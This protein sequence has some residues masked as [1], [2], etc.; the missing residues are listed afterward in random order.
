MDSLKRGWVFQTNEKVTI[1][2]TDY[3]RVTFFKNTPDFTVD[4]YESKKFDKRS[5]LKGDY[6]CPGTLVSDCFGILGIV[7]FT[8]GPYLVVVTDAKKC[9]T[10]IKE[11]DVYSI[12]GKIL[13]PLFYPCSENDMETYYCN[14]FN[15]FDIS[16]NFYFSYTYNIA[17]SLQRNV[18]YA[19]CTREDET[20]LR[21]DAVCATQKYRYNFVH[22][23][24]FAE[25]FGRDSV[26][27]CLTVIHGFF[28]QTNVC[29]SGRILAVHLIARR[30]RFYAG[31]RYK[32]RGISSD[33]H[34][35]ND[36]ETEQILDDA[37]CTASV[38]SFLQVRGS[39]PAFWAQDKSKTIM[40]KPPLI[41]TQNDPTFT[42]QKMHISELLSLY[43][44]PIIMLNLLSDDPGTEEGKLSTQFQSAISSINVEL[45]RTIRVQYVHRN[46][47]SA[48][49][50][51]N[52]RQM[53]AEVVEHTAGEVGFFHERKGNICNLQLGVLRTSCLDCLDRTGV[54][55]LELGLFVFQ[56]QLAL[57][58]I[59]VKTAEGMCDYEVHNFTDE[60][61]SNSLNT[62]VVPELEPLVYLFKGMF[63]GMGDALAMQ[64]AGSKTLRKYEGPR[65]A[66]SRSLQL[67]T[68]LKRGFSSH[69]SDSDRQTL[70][71]I[72]LGVLRPE[73]HPPPWLVDVDKYVHHEKFLCE[74][75]SVEWWVVPLMCFL[76]RARK[77]QSNVCR[78]WFDLFDA[79]GEYLPWVMFAQLVASVQYSKDE[80]ACWRRYA[81]HSSEDKEKSSLVD[82]AIR[83]N[84]S[85]IPIESHVSRSNSENTEYVELRAGL[86][87]GVVLITREDSE[88]DELS[89]AVPYAPGDSTEAVM[90]NAQSAYQDAFNFIRHTRKRN[91]HRMNSF[92][93]PWRI[94]PQNRDEVTRDLSTIRC[95]VC[96]VERYANYVNL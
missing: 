54:M 62:S 6:D 53:I 40:K 45:P 9:G 18:M 39:A 7:S 20:W 91:V 48:L 30:S 35:A 66:I 71:N 5:F 43:G 10:L 38:F 52:I 75:E 89:S 96:D 17:N 65:G 24:N 47:R 51:G 26:G 81:Y 15:Q 61:P 41:Y 88:Q 83:H 4:V 42:A 28:G 11:H 95:R 87:P 23:K 67:F 79:R 13:V 77:L 33:G 19:T 44:S 16:N 12:G 56:R 46:I 8:E 50:R 27:L 86:P 25:H 80:G 21:F 82:T 92:L 37:T 94:Q 29:L 34:V 3:R 60:T 55:A 49:E 85:V 14:L 32:K 93:E 2:Q 84:F 64:Y 63:E 31:T 90:V 70:S 69:F 57:L 73:K 76:R 68:T 59:H 78:S 74:Y 36:V 72:F 22:A 1:L 58:G